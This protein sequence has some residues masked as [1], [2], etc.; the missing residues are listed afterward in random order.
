FK[1]SVSQDGEYWF[2]IVAADKAGNPKTPDFS[3]TASMLIVVVDT[4][5]PE[6]EVRALPPTGEGTFVE[7]TIRDANPDPAL[8][9]VEYESPVKGWQVLEVQPGKPGSF[10]LPSH[11]TLPFPVRV[12]ASDRAGNVTTRMVNLTP[13]P[14]VA[15][16]LPPVESQSDK[17]TLSLPPASL[18]T[19][20]AVAERTPA[21]MEN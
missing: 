17:P 1:C 3:Q 5:Q 4:Q 8:T 21:A 6:V 7:C 14:E 19:P 12:T 9:K 18:P 2:D 16:S 11:L 13:S 15:S 10:K 20:S